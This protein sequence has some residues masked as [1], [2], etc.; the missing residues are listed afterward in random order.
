M[1]ER[2]TRLWAGAEAEVI[3]YGGLAA[4]ARATGLAISTVQ[5]GRNELRVGAQKKDL[6]NVRRRG[7]GRRPHEV[8][9]PSRRPGV[10]RQWATTRNVVSI[11]ST[12][13]RQPLWRTT[14]RG[15][16]SA[17]AA[18]TCASQKPLRPIGCGALRQSEQ[19]TR[20]LGSPAGDCRAQYEVALDQ[21]PDSSL[22]HGIA[23]ALAPADGPERQAAIRRLIL[24]DYHQLTTLP[25][26]GD[27][28]SYG[29]TSLFYALQK[30]LPPN[31]AGHFLM[32]RRP[33]F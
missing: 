14:S 7:G 20:G 17:L 3:G 5:Q 23:L 25:A 28:A 27:H 33:A 21:L 22:L 8:V 16:S 13:N 12:L 2:M 15:S 9:H 10:A 26:L 24:A 32:R 30:S 6:V 11:F 31:D 1:N 4:V 29:L 19:S 18:T